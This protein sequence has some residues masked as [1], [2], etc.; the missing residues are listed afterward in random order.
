MRKEK[1]LIGLLR[2]L[3]ALLAEEAAR[4]PE[5][6]TRLEELLSRLPERGI[7]PGGP[8]KRSA[9]LPLPDVHAELAA[10][11]ENEFRQWLRDQPIP[12]LRAL[13]RVHDLDSTRRTTKWKEALKLADFVV[14]GLRARLARGSAFIGRG[15][16]LG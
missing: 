16:T 4:N 13:I 11:G 3:V 10:R 9:P 1:E 2:G 8:H 6:A 7:I 12:V 5:F 14:Q 15:T